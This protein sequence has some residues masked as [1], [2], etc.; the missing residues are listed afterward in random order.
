MDTDWSRGDAFRDMSGEIFDV[1]V[2]PNALTCS[3]LDGN[4]VEAAL[5]F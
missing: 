2:N 4:H 1:H 3:I 5:V